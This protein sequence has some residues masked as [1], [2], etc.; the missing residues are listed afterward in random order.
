MFAGIGP[1]DTGKNTSWPDMVKDL[2]C[3]GYEYIST[4]LRSHVSMTERPN[5]PLSAIPEQEKEKNA[6]KIYSNITV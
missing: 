1:V 3:K 2:S 5:I 4:V 6:R